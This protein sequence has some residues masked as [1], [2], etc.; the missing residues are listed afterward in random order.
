MFRELSTVELVVMVAVGSFTLTF[1][2][3]GCG[4]QPSFPKADA[5]TQETGVGSKT[6]S[7][8]KEIAVDLGK[9]VKLEMVLIPAGEFLM[10]SP[11][12]DKDASAEEKPQHRVRITKPFYLGKHP[13]TQEQWEA[14]MASNPSN[15]KGPKNP[16][17]EVSW[18]DCQQFLDKLNAKVGTRNK[19]FL[20]PTEAQWE[21]ACRAGSSTKYCFGDD[22]SELGE[23]GW[24]MA[25]A[26]DRPQ[27]VGQKKPNAFGIYDMHGNLGEWCQ[28][29]YSAG[30]Y[31]NSTTDD[32]S[33]PTT[34]TTCVN[35]GGGWDRPERYCRSA[36]RSY[37]VPEFRLDFVGFRVA[38]VPADK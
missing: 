37:Y 15:F 8:P 38:Q 24:Y 32:P 18:D 21:Y 12:S 16:L 14:I 5:A 13:V 26:S 1:A 9:G 17:E 10:G 22:E 29:W 35:R 4:N 19:R 28:D 36:F 30:Y 7:P 33:G 11:D 6:E 23:Y 20:L 27:P 34:G 3:L 2:M 25:N 31:A